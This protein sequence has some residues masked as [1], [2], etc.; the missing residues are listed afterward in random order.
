MFGK[1]AWTNEEEVLGKYKV[2]DSLRGAYRRR[3]EP[4][5]SRDSRESRAWIT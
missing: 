4:S 2:E 3:G 5:E 1:L